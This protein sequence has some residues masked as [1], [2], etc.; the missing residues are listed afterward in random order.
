[1]ITVLYS[2]LVLGILGAIF[3]LVLAIAAK[4]FAVETDE[5][6]DAIVEILPGANC[7]GCGFAGC[8]AY[9]AA[10]VSGEAATNCCQP[11]GSAVAEKVAG[12]MGV[13]AQDTERCV[14]LVKCS[15]FTAKKKFD[16][17]GIPDCNAAMRLGGGKG[18]NEC[19]DGC[20][21]FGTCV[22]AC[23]FGAISVKN[24]V[25]R[26]DHEKCT[27][28][29]TCAAACPKHIII[30][31]PYTADVT[32]ACSSKEKG[33]ALRKYCDIG[34]IGCGICQKTCEQGAITVVDNLARIDYD[35]CISCGQCA[36]KCPRHLIRDAR[37]N[38]ENETAPV[39]ESVSKFAD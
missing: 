13:A 36:P 34:C 6:Q 12:I 29:M 28:C 11:G 25:A 16:Y 20:L 4:K 1:M 27:G 33:A 15:G 38:T 9:A 22:K 10:V 24:G 18:P 5:R 23:P 21:G 35:K 2:V 14:A 26:V 17:S 7:G 31:V 19:P 8:S 37:L 32:V 39:P 3:G 30:K